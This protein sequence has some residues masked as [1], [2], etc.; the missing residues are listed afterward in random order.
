MRVT[1]LCCPLAEFLSFLFPF[2]ILF[3]FA[4]NGKAQ[5][6][7]HH[8]SDVMTDDANLLLCFLLCLF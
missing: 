3:S 5:N 8:L 4:S 1:S 2:F 6:E 7:F